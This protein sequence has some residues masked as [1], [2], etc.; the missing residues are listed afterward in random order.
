[1][2]PVSSI[3]STLEQTALDISKYRF[4]LD[5]R[6]ELLQPWFPNDAQSNIYDSRQSI[7]QTSGGLVILMA[8]IAFYYALRTYLP[9]CLYFVWIGILI[10]KGVNC[11]LNLRNQTHSTLKIVSSPTYVSDQPYIV[12]SLYLASSTFIQ[13][14]WGWR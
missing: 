3:I 14:L 1:M 2:I 11:R 6:D 13:K 12:N 10:G 4:L 8:I 7:T 9:V 5:L